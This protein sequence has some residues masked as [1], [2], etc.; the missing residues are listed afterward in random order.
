MLTL[1]AKL[2][3]NSFNYSPDLGEP[4][5]M[6]DSYSRYTAINE[7]FQFPTSTL[8]YTLSWN[9]GE[10]SY[11]LSHATSGKDMAVSSLPGELGLLFTLVPL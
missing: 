8:R 1:L 2:V 3:Q 4:F 10:H 7:G 6:E 11:P 9:M 5:V